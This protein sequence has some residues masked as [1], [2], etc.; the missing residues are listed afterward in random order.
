MRGFGGSNC[1]SQW[2]LNLPALITQ[3]H[4]HAPAPHPSPLFLFSPSL[5]QTYVTRLSPPNMS[6]LHSLMPPSPCSPWSEA[7]EGKRA[8][9]G[10]T[11]FEKFRGS[12]PTP[13][14]PGGDTFGMFV[15][16][17]ERVGKSRDDRRGVSSCCDLY[18]E[19]IHGGGDKAR[20]CVWMQDEL[21]SRTSGLFPEPK[22]L[23]YH[24]HCHTQLCNVVC[25]HVA[26]P[27]TCGVHLEDYRLE[28]ASF[29][30]SWDKREGLRGCC[31]GNIS[32]SV[33]CKMSACFKTI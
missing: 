18:L 20:C 27:G 31:R 19:C 15:P 3:P 6:L 26:S 33:W 7:C 24:I 25:T 10:R 30:P 11:R 1:C 8:G 2:G 4:R 13:L 22:L 9:G 16:Y 28:A 5:T 17:N 14:N 12:G 29:N 32:L 23:L 21:L